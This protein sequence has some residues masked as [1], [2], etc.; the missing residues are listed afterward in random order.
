[1]IHNVLR[2]SSSCIERTRTKGCNME[3]MLLMD[4]SNGAGDIGALWVET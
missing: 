3:M 1:M 4:V 2:S